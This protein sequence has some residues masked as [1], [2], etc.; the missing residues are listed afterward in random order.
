MTVTPSSKYWTK[1]EILFTITGKVRWFVS[2]TGYFTVDFQ[3][4][5]RDDDK[6]IIS[7]GIDIEYIRVELPQ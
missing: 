3:Q 7:S 4:V 5:P 6:S 2:S 1:W